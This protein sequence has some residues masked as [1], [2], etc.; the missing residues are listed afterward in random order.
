M[1]E[2]MCVSFGFVFVCVYS[3]FIVSKTEIQNQRFDVE[4]HPHTYSKLLAR[5]HIEAL[6]E[7]ST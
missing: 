1:C 3:Q 2:G 7:T 4:L 5:T 6:R